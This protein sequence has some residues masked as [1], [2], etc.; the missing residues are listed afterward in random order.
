MS[1]GGFP[2]DGVIQ[3]YII[4]QQVNVNSLEEVI[5]H[6]MHLS[7]EKAEQARSEA[8]ALEEALGAESNQLWDPLAATPMRCEL[9]SEAEFAY[10]VGTRWLKIVTGITVA[11]LESRME[12][13]GII[14]GGGTIKIF[15]QIVCGNGKALSTIECHC[16]LYANMDAICNQRQAPSCILPPTRPLQFLV[17]L[18]SIH[19][20]GIVKAIR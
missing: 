8:Q 10:G 9:N 7:T 13:F 16:L 1:K 4:C 5:K 19:V 2:K 3:Y 15:F 6:F 14:I 18:G 17:H 11:A 20:L 12:M